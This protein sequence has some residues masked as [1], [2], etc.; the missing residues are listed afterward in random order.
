MTTT[1]KFL[2]Q[3]S[4]ALTAIPLGPVAFGAEEVPASIRQ[5]AT[6]VE[7][8]RRLTCFDEAMKHLDLLVAAGTAEST[9]VPA[10]TAAVGTA[11][12]AGTV[13]AVDA[14]TLTP[15]QKFG[16]TGELKQK[17]DPRP[18]E[19][20]LEQL[21]ANIKDVRQTSAGHYVVTLDNGQVWRQVTPAPMMM[22]AGEPVTI[23]PR[24][25]G[26]FWMVDASGRGSRVK[27]IQ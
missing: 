3:T 25:L 12:A 19:P 6:V 21:T 14:P 16:A 1:A 2:L 5:C 18:A 7:D 9:T 13:A 17:Q 22:K 24:A 4:I 26:S 15:E 27:R 11:A 20:T 8:E 10:T 23:K